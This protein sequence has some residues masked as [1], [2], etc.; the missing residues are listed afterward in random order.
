[1]SVDIDRA[2]ENLSFDAP[3]EGPDQ[4]AISE[5][6]SRTENATST[7]GSIQRDRIPW[8]RDYRLWLKEQPIN[9]DDD[10]GS[11]HAFA[12]TKAV[13]FSNFGKVSQTELAA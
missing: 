6:A 13:F 5:Y 11:I 9:G 4:D 1:M 8:G 2:M 10:P 3:C 12:M 7:L